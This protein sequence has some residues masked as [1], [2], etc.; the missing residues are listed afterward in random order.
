MVERA[1]PQLAQWG[2]EGPGGM[3]DGAGATAVESYHTQQ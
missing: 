3:L 2:R 1:L